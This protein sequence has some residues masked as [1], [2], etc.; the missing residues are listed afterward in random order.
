MRWWLLWSVSLQERCSPSNIRSGEG[1]GG[2]ETGSSSLHPTSDCG[3]WKHRMPWCEFPLQDANIIVLVRHPLQW[4]CSLQEQT[5]RLPLEPREATRTNPWRWL[6][7][8][9]SLV[10]PRELHRTVTMPSAMHLWTTSTSHY[11]AGTWLPV[12]LQGCAIAVR[13]EDLTG[14]LPAVCQELQRLGLRRSAVPIAALE[15]LKGRRT[16]E[17]LHRS[18]QEAPQKLEQ[19]GIH[20]TLLHT[21]LSQPEARNALSRLQ[22]DMGPGAPFLIPKHDYSARAAATTSRDKRQAPLPGSAN[23]KSAKRKVRKLANMES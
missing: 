4:A 11:L 18:Q 1:S 15:D 8:E 23:S 6:L 21:L 14:N 19:H 10:A 9:I 7:E 2:R 22:Y 20:K 17:E 5:W 12:H 3:Q 16:P 13:C